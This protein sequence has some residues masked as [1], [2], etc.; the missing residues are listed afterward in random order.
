MVRCGG[1]YAL[2]GVFG[3]NLLSLPVRAG[4][5]G[6]VDLEAIHPDISFAGFGVAGDDA[7][8]SDEASSVLR[9]ALKDGEVEQ[10]EVVSLDHFFAGTGSDR[11]GEKFAG[12]GEK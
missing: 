1:A 11:L 8:E 7:R 6:V 4:G 2:A 10:G 12:F 5:G 3:G 9:P